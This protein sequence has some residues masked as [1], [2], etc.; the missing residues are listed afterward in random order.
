MR[1]NLS[2][3]M[4]QATTGIIS[5]IIMMGGV[6]EAQSVPPATSFPGPY[7]QAWLDAPYKGNDP[8]LHNGSEVEME[9]RGDFIHITYT[10]P[11]PNLAAAG[12]IKGTL[13]FSGRREGDFAYGVAYTFKTNCP[14]AA[15]PVRGIFD[16]Q[17]NLVLVG[18][19]PKRGIGCEIVEYSQSG[20]NNRLVFREAFGDE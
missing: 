19:A 2:E 10:K 16:A 6:A 11:R 15:Y 13:L 14:P 8:Y 4:I 9:D 17:Q 12:I 18:S 1:A 20:Q 3:K 7:D 5:V